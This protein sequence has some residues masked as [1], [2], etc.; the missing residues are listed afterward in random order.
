METF[1]HCRLLQE[2]ISEKGVANLKI[3]S[4][5]VDESIPIPKTF[6]IALPSIYYAV[7]G[8]L[9]RLSASGIL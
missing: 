1:R 9:Y 4:F 5:Q 2:K 8:W 3:P 7:D 6:F